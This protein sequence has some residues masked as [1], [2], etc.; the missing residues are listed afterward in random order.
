MIK[1]RTNIRVN[2]RSGRVLAT[3]LVIMTGL[4]MIGAGCATAPPTPSS[5]GRE[6]VVMT[7]PDT[8]RLGVARLVNATD[9]I[10]TGYRFEPQDSVFI[11]MTPVDGELDGEAG[12]ILADAVVDETGH[13]KTE[14][15]KLVKI[16]DLL[17]ADVALNEDMENY[18]IIDGPPIP[19]GTYRLVA[20]SMESGKTASCL[21]EVKGPSWGDRFKDWL[22]RRLGKIEKR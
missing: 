7:R 12:L 3:A 11:R 13:F 1:T 18:I 8:I 2:T 4:I 9:I 20:E 5:S 16:T 17:R 22:G 21:L 6:P 19:V 15:E 10:I 14:V